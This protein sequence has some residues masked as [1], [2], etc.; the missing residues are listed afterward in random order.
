MANE[1]NP[2]SVQDISE[3]PVLVQQEVHQTQLLMEQNQ[4]LLQQNRMLQELLNRTPDK[5]QIQTGFDE[6]QRYL[7]SISRTQKNEHYIGLVKFILM[8]IAA[9][10]VF[11]GLYRIWSYFGVLTQML[12]EYAERFSSSFDGFEE[13]FGGLEETMQQI[14]EFFTNLKDFLHLG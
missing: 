12:S 10:L 14:E 6:Q 8:A 13:A 5:T 7:T 1:N 3:Y 11:Y 2:Q 9:A 4:L